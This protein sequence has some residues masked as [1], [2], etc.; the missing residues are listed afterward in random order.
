VAVTG[1]V[2]VATCG[3]LAAPSNTITTGHVA[4]PV[5]HPADKIEYAALAVA[6]RTYSLVFARTINRVCRREV[7]AAALMT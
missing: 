3:L 4:T 7:R 1:D 6:A 2:D 5:A